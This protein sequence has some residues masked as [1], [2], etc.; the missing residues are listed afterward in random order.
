MLWFD[1]QAEDAATYYCS[2]FKNSRITAIGRW[3][4]GGP[5]PAGA[6]LTVDFELDGFKVTGLNAGPQFKFTEAVSFVI[7]CKDQAEVGYYWDKL[8]ADGGQESQCGWLKDKFGFNWQ[9]CPA[10]WEKWLNDPDPERVQRM[11]AAMYTMQKLDIQ[12]LKDAADGK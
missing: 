10:D 6:V 7:D 2:V 11:T 5:G 3:P 8:T 1:G 4:E 9:V 12:A